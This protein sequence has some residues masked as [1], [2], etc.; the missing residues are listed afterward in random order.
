MRENEFYNRVSADR[1][2]S[3]HVD[4]LIGI[5]RGVSA[6]ERLNVAE[7]EFVMKWLAASAAVSDQPLIRILYKKI[8]T[9]LADGQIDP[10][11]H[12]DLLDAMNALASREFELGEVL[13]ATTLP[14]CN[15]APWLDFMGRRYS[16]TGTFI[17]GERNDCER[18]VRDR[19]GDAGSLTQKTNVLVIGAYAT[20]SWKHSSFGNKIIKAC[21]MRDDGIPISIVSEE[22]WTSFL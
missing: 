14:L 1:L 12:D 3:R 21:E 16:F 18:A 7:A 20:E 13:K 11:E 4:E 8:E 9:A 6:D 19:G 17:F 5:V 10:D 22:H 15:P 2:S